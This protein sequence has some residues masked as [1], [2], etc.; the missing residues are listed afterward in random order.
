M[1][2]KKMANTIVNM[3]LSL[4]IVASVAAV[5]LAS[6]YNATKGPIENVKKQKIIDALGSVLPDFDGEPVRVA[7]LPYDGGKDSLIL[8]YAYKGDSLAGI[9]VE[10]YS[11]MGFTEQIK[12]MVG[13]KPDFSINNTA[14]LAHKETPGLGDK[15]DASKSDFPL[16]FI[17]KNPAEFDLRV[18]KDGGQAD[19]ITAATITSRAFCDAVDRAYKTLVSLKDKEE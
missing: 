6:V 13:F 1:A 9:A 8:Y 15:M 14:V 18:T 7:V 19:A 4:F 11:N 5:A 16:Q 12:I 17:D 3:A 10:T 2:K